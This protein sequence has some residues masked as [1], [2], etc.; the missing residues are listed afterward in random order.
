MPNPFGAPEITVHE[1]K[2]RLDDGEP[3]IWLD[4]REPNEQ[5]L[6]AIADERVVAAPLSTIAQRYLDA[7]PPVALDKDADII[8]FCHHGIRSAQVTVWLQ[9]QGWTR[10]LNMAGGIDAWAKEVDRTVGVY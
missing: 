8:V 9:N 6:A 2:N 10:V 1:V 4:V 7:L 3:F 5:Q